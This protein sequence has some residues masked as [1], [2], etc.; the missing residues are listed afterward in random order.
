MW[1]TTDLVSQTLLTLCNEVMQNTSHLDLSDA[2]ETAHVLCILVPQLSR[3]G[4]KF[5]WSHD[6]HLDTSGLAE[7][8]QVLR[9]PTPHS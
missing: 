3:N 2:A 4:A 7:T 6:S 8:V 1:L 9:L 5:H